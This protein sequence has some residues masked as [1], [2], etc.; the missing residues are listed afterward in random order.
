[1]A[2]TG[3]R[4][5]INRV[6]NPSPTIQSNPQISKVLSML[7]NGGKIAD[8]G[9]GG[10]KITPD[11]ITIDFAKIGDTNIVADIHNIPLKDNTIDCLFCTGTLEHVKYPETVLKEILRVL[12]KDGIVYIDVPF[13]QCYHP[14]P[15]DYWRFT[16][17][18]IE[19]I[20]TRNGFTKIETGVNIGSASSV[21]WVLM[22][23]FHTIFLNR[24]INKVFSTFFSM[25]VSPIKYLDKYTIKGEN[26]IIAP[27][28]VYFIGAK[29]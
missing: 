20:C 7:T 27:S 16:I 2:W 29:K 3:N 28:A 14:D 25:L 5:I 13:M 1:M 6:L 17:K 15:V 18:G 24:I 21:T 22:A 12:R 11:C 10:R 8:L 23:F 26:K 19:L 4:G 9:A